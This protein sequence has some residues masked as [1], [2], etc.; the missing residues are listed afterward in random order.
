MAYSDDS[1]VFGVDV[2]GWVEQHRRELEQE[3]EG[4]TVEQLEEEIETWQEAFSTAPNQ[5]PSG[6][7]HGLRADHPD[8][9][10]ERE[11]EFTGMIAFARHPV[12]QSI[13]DNR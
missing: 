4:R 10:A 13:N 9:T 12:K 11:T 8:A 5:R 1:G 3:A 2:S 7:A 6:I